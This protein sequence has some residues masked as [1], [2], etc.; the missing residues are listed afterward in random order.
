M[1]RNPTASPPSSPWAGRLHLA[2]TAILFLAAVSIAG[3]AA[4]GRVQFGGAVKPVAPEVADARPKP[5]AMAEEG[6][7]QIEKVEDFHEIID[8]AGK[9]FFDTEMYDT[10]VFKYKGGLVETTLEAELGGETVKI[11]A[12]PENWKLAMPTRK[13]E[14]NA[15]EPPLNYT[16][17]IIVSAVRPAVTVEEALAPYHA[18]LGALMA[19]GPGGPLDV[20]SALFLEVRQFRPYRIF[21][22]ANPPPDAAGRGFNVLDQDRAILVGTPLVIKNPTLEEAVFGGGKNLQ[23]G[24]KEIIL[25]RQRGYTRIRL[26]ARFLTD[27]EARELLPK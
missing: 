27:G 3:L 2:L 15:A 16:G 11:A 24:K 8:R 9:G 4:A 26:E 20:L 6:R 5:K 12:V 22:S 14:A 1:T 25:D 19:F 17:Y 21:V 18:H 23:P 13:P 7:Y 10:W